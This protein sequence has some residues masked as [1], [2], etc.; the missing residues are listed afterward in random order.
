MT[1]WVL[2]PSSWIGVTAGASHWYGT[3]RRYENGSRRSVERI[4]LLHTMSKKDAAERNRQD[5]RRFGTAICAWK[6]GEE[7]NAF[8]SE[9][10]LEREAR[11]VFRERAKPGDRLWR[12][13]EWLDA[14]SDEVMEVLE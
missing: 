1:D 10:A 14:D 13:V 12:S 9:D 5:R 8:P 6:A 7:V 2:H 11:R 3:L 4:D